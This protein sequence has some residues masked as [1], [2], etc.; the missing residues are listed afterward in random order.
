MI[1]SGT[2]VPKMITNGFTPEFA[3]LLFSVGSS[4]TYA[5]TPA[6]A[7]FVIYIAFMEKY[8]K[9]G[10]GLTKGIKYMMPYTLAISA[11]WIV[12]II[13]WYLVGLPL[14]VQTLVVA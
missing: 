3:Q 2:I 11:M 13:I 5:I 4:L 9:E 14:G 12:L 1:L 10:I 6:M 8:D 7:Y